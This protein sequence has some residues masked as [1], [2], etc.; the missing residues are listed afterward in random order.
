MAFGIVVWTGPIMLA[1]ELH[2]Y[3]QDIHCLEQAC[4]WYIFLYIGFD[5]ISGLYF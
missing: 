5:H 2:A 3:V 4:G 1:C